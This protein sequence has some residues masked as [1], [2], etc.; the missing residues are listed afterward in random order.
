MDCAIA[1][2]FTF[3]MKM[4]LEII[5]ISLTKINYSS[6]SSLGTADLITGSESGL[7]IAT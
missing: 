1:A 6:P 5:K 3:L 4:Y 2:Q 7:K